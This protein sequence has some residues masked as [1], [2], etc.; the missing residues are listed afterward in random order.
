MCAA[1][2]LRG[3]STSFVLYCIPKC[4]FNDNKV[5]LNWQDV[6]MTLHNVAFKT[7]SLI[8]DQIVLLHVGTFSF[9]LPLLEHSSSIQCRSGGPRHYWKKIL[10]NREVITWIGKQ[11]QIK[12]VLIPWKSERFLLEEIWEKIYVWNISWHLLVF[13]SQVF[14]G[15]KT[16]YINDFYLSN[17]GAQAVKRSLLIG[18]YTNPRYW[19]IFY[20]NPDNWWAANAW[21]ALAAG[22]RGSPPWPAASFHPG[23]SHR[24]SNTDDFII[25][26]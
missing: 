15:I 10:L 25:F 13:F 3:Q 20:G 23:C 22:T 8:S 18:A 24:K 9:E 4:Q 11:L 17:F 6:C 2:R 1:P 16:I 12:S 21:E 5:E 26:A 7:G 19:L 14:T